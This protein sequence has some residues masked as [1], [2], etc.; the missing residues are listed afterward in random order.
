MKNTLS[1]R[2]IPVEVYSRSVGYFRP[3][4]TWNKGKQSE[5]SERKNLSIEG[6]LE[7]LKKENTQNV[8]YGQHQSKNKS[9]TI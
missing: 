3:V 9:E 2:K 5:F 1:C 6:A 8:E 7:S 4:F